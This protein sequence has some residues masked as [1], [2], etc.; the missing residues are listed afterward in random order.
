MSGQRIT[1][2]VWGDLDSRR[3]KLKRSTQTIEPLK[4]FAVFG[5]RY[6]GG[7]VRGVSRTAM[8]VFAAP[9]VKRIPK[10]IFQAVLRQNSMPPEAVGYVRYL[11][12]PDEPR[13]GKLPGFLPPRSGG[14]HK[15]VLTRH[16]Q[17]SRRSLMP[18]FGRRWAARAAVSQHTAW[19]Q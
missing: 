10:A 15:Y 13:L 9:S 7:L 14:G 19:L 17:S 4:N 12:A 5:P 2:G 1:A 16:L 8:R 18:C 11:S 6:R 3:K